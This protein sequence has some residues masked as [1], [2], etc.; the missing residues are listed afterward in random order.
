MFR[1]L[2]WRFAVPVLVALSVGAWFAVPY[3]DRMLTEWFRTDVDMRARVVM[4]S[5]GETLPTLL[6]RSELPR[7]RRFLAKVTEDETNG[8]DELRRRGHG[9]G[10]ERVAHVPV[11]AGQVRAAGVRGL[12]AGGDVAVFTDPQ[13]VVAPLFEVAGHLARR[14]AVVAVG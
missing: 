5:M 4:N 7:L 12:A 14:H 1:T 3:V 10:H 8:V 2:F 6:D 11:E 13:R 9:E